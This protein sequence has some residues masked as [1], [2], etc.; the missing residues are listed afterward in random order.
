MTVDPH[1]GAGTNIAPGMNDALSC[2]TSETVLA[3]TIPYE[4][5]RFLEVNLKVL[6]H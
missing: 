3:E 4:V 5:A 2:L 6:L 1:A